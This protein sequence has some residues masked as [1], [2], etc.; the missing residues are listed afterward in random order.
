MFLRGLGL[1]TIPVSVQG[2]IFRSVSPYSR[3]RSTLP[4][5]IR[6]GILNIPG[7]SNESKTT[8][9][10]LLQ[11]DRETYHCFF[12]KAGLHNHLSHQ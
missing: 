9:E 4:P 6:P 10:R 8:V 7:A 3:M 12:G 1:Q 11:D 2:R 5:T